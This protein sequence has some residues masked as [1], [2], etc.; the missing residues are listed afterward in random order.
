LMKVWIELCAKFTDVW[1]IGES[2][3]SFLS[4]DCLR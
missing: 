4:W 2:S 1:L 3:Q